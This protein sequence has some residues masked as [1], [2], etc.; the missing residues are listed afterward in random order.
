M[1]LHALKIE[2]EREKVCFSEDNSGI[3]L[4]LIGATVKMPLEN[5]RINGRYQVFW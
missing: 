2:R 4:F 1:E 3:Y 5:Q